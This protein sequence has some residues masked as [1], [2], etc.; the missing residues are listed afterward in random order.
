MR[1]LVSATG[2]HE[3]ALRRA[4]SRLAS[5][6]SVHVE[7]DPRTTRGRPALRYR[8]AGTPDEPF[9]HFL[10]LL[11]ELVDRASVA[12]GVAYAIGLAHGA[13]APA[14]SPGGAPEAVARLLVALG[15]DPH[16]VGASED[17]ATVLELARCPFADAVTSGHAGWRI[18]ELHHGQL[19]GLARARGGSLDSFTVHDP[20]IGRCRLAVR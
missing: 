6:G 9:R 4:L 14:S 11:L 18:C 1:E 19:A 7:Q 17:G 10:P 16:R 15:F 13:A 3:N 2:L 8:L 5:D 20:R 12:D